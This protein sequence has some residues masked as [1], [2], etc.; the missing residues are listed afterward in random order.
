VIGL[1]L[2][3]IVAALDYVANSPIGHEAWERACRAEGI[4]C[5]YRFQGGWD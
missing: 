4:G 5:M 3:A 2:L 1:A